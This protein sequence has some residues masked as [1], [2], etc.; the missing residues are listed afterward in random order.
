MVMQQAPR[1]A[2]QA[3]APPRNVAQAGAH[4]VP[5]HLMYIAV[6]TITCLLLWK[7]KLIP[8]AFSGQVR[9]MLMCF[10]GRSVEESWS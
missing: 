3:G 5:D 8:F 4:H 1:N 2:A 7:S 10:W 9:M 6:Y